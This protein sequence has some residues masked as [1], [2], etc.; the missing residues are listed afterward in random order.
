MNTHAN[1]T[2]NHVTMLNDVKKFTPCLT[3]NLNARDWAMYPNT[4]TVLVNT[5]YENTIMSKVAIA[6]YR[7]YD[8]T[9]NRNMNQN[10]NM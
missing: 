7:K 1:N 8:G 10:V 5:L 2:L 4:F 3:T 6:M 9:L